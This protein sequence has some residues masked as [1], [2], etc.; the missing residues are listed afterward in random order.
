MDNILQLLEE[1]GRLT[2]DQLAVMLG[3]E[4]NEVKAVIKHYEDTG[5]ILGY[6]TLIDWDKTEREYVSAIIELK[7]A[8]Q[9]D[10]GFDRIAEKI[11]NYP[12]VKSVALMSGGF[13]LLLTLEG[14]TLKEVAYFVA[15]K[16][17]PLEDVVS[18]AT[19]FVLKKYKDKGIV[20][21]APEVDERGNIL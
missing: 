3:R 20:Y 18:T 19:H 12:E 21:G 2:A 1:N 16:L 17:A 11:Y 9:R 6:T 15:N 14:K 7:V 13:D 5:V 4:K 10:R 8:P